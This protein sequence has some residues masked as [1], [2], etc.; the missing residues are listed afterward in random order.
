MSDPPFEGTQLKILQRTL[1]LLQS[2]GYHALTMTS[3]AA[4]CGLT[5][6]GLYHHFRRKEDIF[7][8]IMVLGNFEARNRADWTAQKALAQNGSALDIVTDWLDSRFGQTRRA[9]ARAPAGEELNQVAFSMCNDIMIEVSYQ[10]NARLAALLEELCRRGKL[11]LKPG[12]TTAELAL[13]I[14]D[15]ARGVN[16]QRPPAPE[17]EIARRYRRVTAAILYG[18][19][20]EP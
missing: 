4:A 8:A 3:I 19:A 17:N 9:V 18:T 15:G 14:G 5:R 11:M 12:R 6:R 20:F 2:Q 13:I 7:R 16:Q 1:P 10:T